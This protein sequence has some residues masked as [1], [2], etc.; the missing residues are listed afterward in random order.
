MTDFRFDAEFLGITGINLYR[1]NALSVTQSTVSKQQRKLTAMKMSR[2]NQ[3]MAS[4]VLDPPTLEER[5]V[6]PFY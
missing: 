4:S 3:P 1:P 2:V 5:D 6:Y